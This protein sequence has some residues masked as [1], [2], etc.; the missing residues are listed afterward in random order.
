MTHMSQFVGIIFFKAYPEIFRNKSEPRETPMYSKF[1]GLVVI[2][3]CWSWSSFGQQELKFLKFRDI[4]Q[5]LEEHEVSKLKGVLENERII[6]LDKSGT[7]QISK[8][9]VEINQRLTDAIERVGN[10]YPSYK[11]YL[12]ANSAPNAF[13]LKSKLPGHKVYRGHVFLSA[14]ML[15]KIM[16]SVGVDVD[17]GDLSKMKN[18][19][20]MDK[21][22]N[23]I[24][25]VI[26][27]EFMHPKQDELVKW[28]WRHGHNNAPKAHMQAD[29]LATDTM[30]PNI[31]REAQLPD[32]SMLMAI[33]HGV[34]NKENPNKGIGRRVLE[35]GLS[36]HP[37]DVFR[38]SMARG[39]LAYLRIDEGKGK[40][41][42]LSFN[43]SE[44]IK[45][46]QT[47]TALNSP[48]GQILAVARGM[49][50]RTDF[51]KILNHLRKEQGRARDIFGPDYDGLLNYREHIVLL[52][53][54][55]GKDA[56]AEDEMKA[57]QTFFDE[58]VHKHRAKFVTEPRSWRFWEGSSGSRVPQAMAVS[59][60]DVREIQTLLGDFAPIHDPKFKAN[61]ES[62]IQ[63][64]GGVLKYF[65]YE[66]GGLEAAGV[67]LPR[68]QLWPLFDKAINEA[69]A[70]D[71]ETRITHLIK[72]LH[73]SSTSSAPPDLELKILT[74]INPMLESSPSARRI[75]GAQISNVLKDSAFTSEGH[76]TEKFVRW[77]KTHPKTQEDLIRSYARLFKSLLKGE[78]LE[79]FTRFEFNRKKAK[80][81]KKIMQMA[82]MLDDGKKVAPAKL[83]M[84]QDYVLRAMRELGVKEAVNGLAANYQKS[85]KANRSVDA[86]FPLN[87]AN[88][89]MENNGLPD[90]QPKAHQVFDVFLPSKL[91]IESKDH[92]GYV[93]SLLNK[94]G[95]SREDIN[96][97]AEYI[98]QRLKKDSGK[99][100]MQV[101]SMFDWAEVFN[102][103]SQRQLSFYHSLKVAKEISAEELKGL[104]SKH[105]LELENKNINFRLLGLNRQ[106]TIDVYEAFAPE[107]RTGRVFI[108]DV[109]ERMEMEK[110]N[111]VTAPDGHS[112]HDAKRKAEFAIDAELKYHPDYS[113]ILANSRPVII[114]DVKKEMGL[115]N[116]PRHPDYSAKFKANKAI[117]MD[118]VRLIFNPDQEWPG[119]E[120]RSELDFGA[121]DE[122]AKKL[123][124][125]VPEGVL[126]S[127]EALKTWK[128]MTS[129]RSMRH[130]DEFYQKH[131]AA[132]YQQLP[133]DN[134]MQFAQNF[135]ENGL[136]RSERTKSD[137]LQRA[138]SAEVEALKIRRPHYKDMEIDKLVKKVVRF[139]PSASRYRDD[140]LE[141]I[142]WKLELPEKHILKFIQPL[143]SGNFRS[144]N[145]HQVTLMSMFNV[146]LEKLPKKEKL[147]LVKYIQRP[148]GELLHVVPS[149]KL[150]MEDFRRLYFE[151]FHKG[152]SEAEF[153]NMMDKFETLIRDAGDSERLAVMEMVVG[154]KGKGLWYQGKE[155]QDA[156]LEV[157]DIKGDTLKYFNAYMKSIPE[158]ERTI[159]LS[160][161]MATEDHG[162]DGKQL[163]RI[164]E[165]HKTPGIKFA[166]VSSIMAVFGDDQS[167]ILAAAKDKSS[168][169]QRAEAFAQLR[170]LYG[171]G[172]YGKVARIKKLAGSG[173]IK[174]VLLVE[175]DDGSTEAVY[176]KRA[177]LDATNK[178]VF[179]V[180]ENFVNELRAVDPDFQR[181]YDYD[182]YLRSLKEQIKTETD[183]LRELDLSKKMAAKYEARPSVEGWKFKALK[184][185]TK[186]PQEAEI[187]H[188]EAAQNV[189]TFD[190]LSSE[191]KVRVSKLIMDTELDFL[192][193]DGVF[194][195]DRHMGNFLFD[196]EKKIVYPIDFSQ[197]YELKG[198]GLL[199][200]GDRSQLAH[201]LF[202]LSSKNA[203]EGAGMI[204]KAL[205]SIAENAKDL[206]AATWARVRSELKTILAEGSD[207]RGKM[208][209]MLSLMTKEKVRMPMKWS[210]GIFKGMMIITNEDYSKHY[211]KA[212]VAKR[213]EHFV[214]KNLGLEDGIKC[215]WNKIKGVL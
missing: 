171:E 195:A 190:S 98:F 61:L 8:I 146:A 48:E 172:R 96:S 19:R 209:A 142:A 28:E 165:L 121:L 84:D 106:S 169:I 50:G 205:K 124:R 24:T 4:I 153:N 80:A 62:D 38:H 186:N 168:P 47:L 148:E 167:K 184:P 166:Q 35:A 164:L 89:F 23:A 16:E 76:F 81:I 175:F 144:V 149:I 178:S 189:V 18:P 132:W 45:E 101:L 182:F 75:F 6:D 201:L 55:K 52:K 37:E 192:L 210:L 39:T 59:T 85:S 100:A 58:L 32:E 107:G 25:G 136:L 36:S 131:L 12:T 185:S 180:A 123:V 117:Y 141:A 2:L 193:K 103:D 51:I 34:M 214:L 119:L 17:S 111:S 10:E 7:K 163:L 9:L 173:G 133:E 211:P 212:E 71:D 215:F 104:I 30:A 60:E 126:T 68:N 188:F 151:L 42:P 200:K 33:E 115:P 3:L 53:K 54:L 70:L 137:M 20:I 129:K 63:K 82:Y 113:K 109:L 202:G 122:T 208:L 90:H 116:D 140:Y 105:Y 135:L 120:I 134:K 56:L 157:A 198:G 204:E 183:F 88:G 14:G 13:I 161:L 150:Y 125:M 78:E 97:F 199:S 181:K 139:M 73:G 92:A 40:V 64:A 174:H 114:R 127:E 27:H 26:A 177:H 67:L 203:D 206:D 187:L 5:D 159:V 77:T 86:L 138:L 156:L 99:S 108:K 196:S 21:V 155:Y 154:A 176:I 46:L 143:K 29:E 74:E 79:Y 170:K 118:Y 31:L 83:V 152:F 87:V 22:V 194:D 93:K 207:L 65:A 160:Y 57:F 197:V 110:Y 15:S 66:E 11:I 102:K 128:D 179:E 72:L 130:S 1:L 44:L 91:N 94:V 147:S 95:G 112:E 49:E 213:F 191:D 43:R 69:R 41:I 162:D 158:H 145:P